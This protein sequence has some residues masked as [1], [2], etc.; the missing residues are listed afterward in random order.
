MPKLMFQFAEFPRRNYLTAI[1]YSTRTP[2]SVVGT[3]NVFYD[4]NFFSK[5]N[6]I[7]YM[8]THYFSS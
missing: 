2:G 1:V 7:F 6:T 3:L 8:Y 4:L 5:R